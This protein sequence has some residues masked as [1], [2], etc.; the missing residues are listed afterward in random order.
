MYLIEI[1]EIDNRW[2]S[3]NDQKSKN[4]FHKIHI[5]REIKEFFE[6]HVG[7]EFRALWNV[8]PSVAQHGYNLDEAMTMDLTLIKRD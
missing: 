6:N 2:S 5:Y 3:E 4:F 8:F 7:K 1:E